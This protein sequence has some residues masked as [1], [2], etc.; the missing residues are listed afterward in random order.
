MK[1]LFL[2]CVASGCFAWAFCVAWA[3]AVSLEYAGSHANLVPLFPGGGPA[4]VQN[5]VVVPWRSEILVKPLDADGNNAYGTDGYALFAT[6]FSYPNANLYCCDAF[7]DPNGNDPLFPNIID[8]PGWV[9]ESQILAERMAGGYAYA[10]IDDPVLTHGYRDYNWGDTQSPPSNPPHGQA[11]YVKM[12]FLDGWDILGNNPSEEPAGRWGFTVGA[13]VPAAFRVGVMTGG[14]DNGNFAPAEVFLQE[15]IGITPVG[16][17][18]GT[19]TLTGAYKDPFVDM[20]FFDIVGA[21][22]GD[23]FVFGVMSGPDSF[24]NSGVA[25]FSFDVLPD[26]Q[27]ADFNEDGAIDGRDFLAWQRGESP[28]PLSSGDLVLWQEQYGNPP[29]TANSSVPEPSTLALFGSVL[30]CFRRLRR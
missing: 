6:T 24:G 2:R 20:H 1:S 3:S 19:G 17:S 18:L 10:L 5:Y 11:P 7:L 29:L 22:E 25:G 4:N 21:E 8:L 14:G 23:Q 12:G 27:S 30:I 9:S 26:V 28:D 13:D 15:F 16:T